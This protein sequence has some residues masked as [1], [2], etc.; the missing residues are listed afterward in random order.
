MA[1]GS[2]LAQN[3]PRRSRLAS[4]LFVLVLLVFIG[5]IAALLLSFTGA[6]SL[7]SLTRILPRSERATQAPDGVSAEIVTLQAAKAAL[8]AERERLETQLQE[9]EAQVQALTAQLDKLRA[10]LAVAQK[11]GSDIRAVAALYE[12]MAAKDAARIFAEMPDEKVLPILLEL[13][14]EQAA[15]ILAAME[16]QRAARLT[17]AMGG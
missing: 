10:D 2:V 1:R 9:K 13:K 17:E 15:A 6:L 11:K 3:P 8:E 4:A 12:N 16:S 5:G 14:K 7:S